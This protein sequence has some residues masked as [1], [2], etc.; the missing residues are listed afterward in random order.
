MEQA[1]LGFLMQGSAHGYALH[2]RAEEELGRIWYMGMSNVYA[3]LK[4][5]GSAGQVEVALD[6]ETYPPRKV[7]SITPAGCAAFS[8]WVREPVD[9]V[10]DMRVELLA[11]LYFFQALELEGA[12]SL[13]RAQGTVCRER[14]DELEQNAAAD[15]DDVFGRVVI[16]F[17]RRRIRSSIEWL[18]ACEKEWR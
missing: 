16:D 9:A 17:R 10:R 5:L 7:Y 18:Q 1:L 15:A 11:K 3:T 14:L 6:E 2:Q 8:A 4:D 13:L 12:L